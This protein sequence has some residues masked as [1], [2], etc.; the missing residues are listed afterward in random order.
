VTPPYGGVGGGAYVTNGGAG[1]GGVGA[2][3]GVY[4][5]NGYSN[6]TIHGRGLYTNSD[7]RVFRTPAYGVQPPAAGGL[8]TSNYILNANGG[9]A[10][11]TNYGVP[12]TNSGAGQP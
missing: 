2:S 1:M 10:F 4:Y 5:G 12:L 3:N 7:G 8:G 6:F 11:A 9:G